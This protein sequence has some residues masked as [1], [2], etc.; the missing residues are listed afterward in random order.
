MESLAARFTLGPA[1]WRRKRGKIEDENENDNEHDCGR[2][3]LPA[4]TDTAHGLKHRKMAGPRIER[5]RLV[6][7]GDFGFGQV[8]V[9]GPRIFVDVLEAGGLG[10]GKEGRSSHQEPEARPGERSP[11]DRQRFALV[12][13]HRKCAVS[14]IAHDQ[15]DYRRLRRHCVSHTRE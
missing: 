13:A 15:T 2:R 3:S 11:G 8:E 4:D 10:N 7:L 9:A 12:R 14:E 5:K 6:D 1:E